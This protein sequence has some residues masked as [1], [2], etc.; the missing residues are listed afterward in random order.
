MF[1]L[2]LI[3]NNLVMK[4]LVFL[5]I[6]LLLLI[7]CGT[8]K[9]PLTESQLKYSGTWIAPGDIFFKI[10]ADGGGSFNFSNTK[11]TGGNVMFTDSGFTIGIFGIEKDFVVNKEPFSDKGDI[12]IVVNGI[13]FKKQNY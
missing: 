6:I 1:S 3:K 7:S 11:V 4:N 9:T 10:S 13:K 2:F 8:K 5:P 12:N